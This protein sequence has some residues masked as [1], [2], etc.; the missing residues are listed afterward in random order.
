MS[1]LHAYRIIIGNIT[2]SYKLLVSITLMNLVT[3]VIV[4]GALEQAS[5]DKEARSSQAIYLFARKS[6]RGVLTIGMPP[7][8][9]SALTHI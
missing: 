9:T 2:V 8:G 5:K 6:K 7:H 1:V 4:E 3:A